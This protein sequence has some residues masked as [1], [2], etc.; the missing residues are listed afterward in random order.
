MASQMVTIYK[1]PV[2]ASHHCP[3]SI[4]L[5]LKIAWS[6]VYAHPLPPEHRFPMEKY[7]LLPE[8]LLYEGTVRECNF[9]EPVPVAEQYIINTHTT[10]YWHRLAQLQLSPAEIR[11]TGFPLSAALVRREVTIARRHHSR[12]PLMP[13]IR[14]RHEHCGGTHHAFT[15]RGEGFCL[16]NDMAIAA[17]YLSGKRVGPQDTDYR[18]GRSPG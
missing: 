2:L 11:R 7:T 12:R 13:S 10:G 5:M 17:N 1:I 9:F 16:L 18:P 6:S 4:S 3:R 14:S 15:D 8:Q